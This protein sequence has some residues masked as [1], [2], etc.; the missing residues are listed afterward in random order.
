MVE[1]T[2]LSCASL[3]YW[4]SNAGCLTHRCFSW[5]KF[6]APSSPWRFF[7]WKMM[8]KASPVI[9]LHQHVGFR[10]LLPVKLIVYWPSTGNRKIEHCC[11]RG[12]GNMRN[13][14]HAQTCVKAQEGEDWPAGCGDVGEHAGF[15]KRKEICKDKPDQL[16]WT[17][18]AWLELI[19]NFNIECVGTSRFFPLYRLVYSRWRASDVSDVSKLAQG[20]RSIG[21]VL[22]SFAG[23]LEV[24]ETVRPK[25]I[26][27]FQSKSDADVGRSSMRYSFL[28][29]NAHFCL[30][31]RGPLVA[32]NLKTE[33]SW[34]ILLNNGVGWN[35]GE[36]EVVDG[37]RYDFLKPFMLDVYRS[38]WVPELVQ[39]WKLGGGFIFFVTPTWGNDPIW[40]TYFS[41]GLKPQTRKGWEKSERGLNQKNI[42]GYWWKIC[43]LS[44][45]RFIVHS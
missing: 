14:I 13:L 8:L 26:K 43:R 35:H 19:M 39:R 11:W 7:S 16:Y 40:Q 38:Y 29:G 34:K 32:D 31:P 28:L 25:I 5:K 21:L 33:S 2:P 24:N 41:N 30:V 12:V 23:Y 18:G 1:P 22:A 3:L 37:G 17:A 15:P 45:C 27:A 36:T 9:T 4:L 20:L 10:P 6:V 42:D 44:Y